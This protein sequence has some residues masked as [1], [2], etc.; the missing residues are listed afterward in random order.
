[1]I[2]AHELTP[3]TTNYDNDMIMIWYD[4]DMIMIYLYWL[5]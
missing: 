4:N 5:L 3:Q 2:L 1:M